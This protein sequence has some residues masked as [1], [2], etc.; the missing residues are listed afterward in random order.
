LKVKQENSTNRWQAEPGFAGFLIGLLSDPVDGR[1]M[2]LQNAGSF[3]TTQHHN[4]EDH[5]F[6]TTT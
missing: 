5:T 6:L 1:N 3:Q 2:F 4:P